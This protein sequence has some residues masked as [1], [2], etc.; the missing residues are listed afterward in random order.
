MKKLKEYI[1]KY[2]TKASNPG[3][4]NVLLRIKNTKNGASF[5]FANNIW[6]PVSVDEEKAVSDIMVQLEKMH[7]VFEDFDIPRVS[8]NSGVFIV[9]IGSNDEFELKVTFNRY[10]EGDEPNNIDNPS[11]WWKSRTSRWSE[12]S[13]ERE[14]RFKNFER[15]EFALLCAAYSKKPFKLK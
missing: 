2:I 6:V 9:F 11:A 5:L 1:T 7:P 13:A 10:G 15:S 8:N 12:T 3:M 4:Y 14:D